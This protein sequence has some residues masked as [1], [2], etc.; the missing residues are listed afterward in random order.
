MDTVPS[1][2]W[3]L[4]LIQLIRTKNWPKQEGVGAGALDLLAL[5]LGQDLLALV[6]AQES[7]FTG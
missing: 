6:D 5:F 1:C 2:P 7:T 4:A 3:L